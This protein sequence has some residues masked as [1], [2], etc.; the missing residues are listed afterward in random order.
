MK[1]Y[2]L[3]AGMLLL[4][5]AM[6]Y[7]AGYQLNLQG[8][9][10]LA[11]GGGGTAIPWDASTIF[12][13]PGGLSAFDHVQAYGSAQFIMPNVKYVQTPYGV[14]MA[15]SVSQT[16]PTFNLYVG[17][18]IANKS[19]VSI[20]LGIYTPF[21]SGLKWDDNW[22]GRYIIQQ[23]D[24]QTIFFQPTISYYI[25]DV[26]SI[27]G[28]LVYGIGNVHLRKALPLVDQNNREA[29]ADLKGTA[30]GLGLNVGIHINASEKV[31]LGVSYR[32]Q[33]NMK[34]PRGYATF[35]VPQSVGSEFP[36]TAFSSELP[37][38]QV[39]SLGIGVKASE[40]I[41]FQ[42]DLNYVGWNAYEELAFD[43][44][45]NTTSL[46]DT[47]SP[48]NYH[49]TLAVR[50]GMQYTFSDKISGMIGAALDPTPVSDNY[51]TPDLPDA[52]RGVFTLGASYHPFRKLTILGAVEFVSSVDRDGTFM[53]EGFGGRYQTRAFTSGL[54]ITYDF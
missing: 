8:L 16:F 2:F 36:Y 13:N 51:V 5:S 41:T 28:G 48:R 42:A 33:V 25:N 12:Y 3:G 38:P 7:G 26:V 52:N 39:L 24:L 15:S 23:I 49:N 43:F 10:Q 46:Q 30:H 31:Q 19:N 4:S 22:A 34:V 50:V 21:G 18:P 1:K 17:G 9:R 11:M 53:D 32:S 40:R 35:S 29:T 44:E 6:T 20:G 27:G 47:R 54:G 37:M 45:R 14:R